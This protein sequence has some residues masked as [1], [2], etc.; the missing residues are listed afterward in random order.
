MPHKYK[1]NNPAQ[2]ELFPETSPISKKKEKP[3][4]ILKDLTLSVENIIVVSIIFVMSLVLFFAFGVE[5]GKNVAQVFPEEK[6]TVEMQTVKMVDVQ[7][8]V[9]PA[10]IKIIEPKVIQ[11]VDIPQ[12][13]V[14][15]DN[16]F[17]IEENALEEG[18]T[19]QVASFKLE[20]SARREATRLKD[21]GHDTFVI[22][23]GSYSIV[24]VG[25]FVQREEAKAFSN[26]LKNR[27]QDLLVRRF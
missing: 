21:A 13:D 6:K 22:P 11:A 8:S 10:K 15:D 18:Y 1:F 2:F 5:R 26:Q 17:P 16:I 27:Y 25:R 7:N 20:K 12:K 24:C 14:V 4:Y 19:I 9:S 3:R 23:K